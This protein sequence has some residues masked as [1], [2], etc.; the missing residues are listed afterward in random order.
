ME[1]SPIVTL[2][3]FAPRASTVFHT[4]HY[5]NVSNIFSKIVVYYQ[6][7]TYIFMKIPI[8][9][10][11]CLSR[12]KYH[13]QIIKYKDLEYYR[14]KKVFSFIYVYILINFIEVYLT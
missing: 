6:A 5:I 12:F 1:S 9:I 14:Y 8:T 10:C 3:T 11:F 13:F 4:V 2:S 7:V